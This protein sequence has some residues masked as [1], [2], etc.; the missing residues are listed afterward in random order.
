MPVRVAVS[1]CLGPGSFTVPRCILIVDD[2]AVVRR[3][4]R[5]LFERNEGWEVC[6]EAVN[7]RDAIQKA[8]ELS[9]DLI[10]LDLSMPEMDGSQAARALR[11]MMPGVPL[12]LFSVYGQDPFVLREAEAA[13]IAAVVPKTDGNRLLETLAHVG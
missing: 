5:Q 12:V 2:S 4:L 7:G 9:P 8:R 11:Q 13:G 10:L 1:R 3:S 6:G